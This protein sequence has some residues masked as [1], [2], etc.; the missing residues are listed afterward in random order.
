MKSGISVPNSPRRTIRCSSRKARGRSPGD[1]APLRTSLEEL[2]NFSESG[3]GR[4]VFFLPDPELLEGV[5]LALGQ[6]REFQVDSAFFSLRREEAPPVGVFGE[7]TIGEGSHLLLYV[8][9]YLRSTSP[10]WYALA[11][12]PLGVLAFLK[13]EVSSSLEA[14]LAVSDYTKGSDARVVLAVMGKSET[15][16]W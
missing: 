3:E 9:P 13:D 10:L 2:G 11:P 12:R 5:V 14:L 16:F 4:I 6:H 7:L 15:T 8:F 1:R